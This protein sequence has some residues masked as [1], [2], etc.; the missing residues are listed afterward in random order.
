MKIDKVVIKNFRNY[1]GEHH[2][3]LS[4]DITIFYGDNGFGKSSFFD[5]IEWCISG[6]I[7]RFNDEGE[8]EKF[9]KDLINRYVLTSGENDIECCITMEFN[10]LKLIRKFN[11]KD[12]VFGNT[13]VKIT[14]SNNKTLR[15]LDGKPINSKEKADEFLSGIFQQNNGTNK[16]MFGKLMKQ[17]YILSQ[18]QVTEFVSS[19]DAVETFR[20]IANIMG[21]KPM[22][23]LSDNMKKIHSA[24]ESKNK[25]LSEDLEEKDKSILSKQ[26]TKRQV[27]I[28]KINTNLN[29]LSINIKDNVKEIK[30]HLVQIR[31]KEFTKKL[32]ADDQLKLCNKFNEE[33]FDLEQVKSKIGEL[34]AIEEMHNHTLESYKSLKSKAE[35]KLLELN[36]IKKDISSY[37]QLSNKIN[38]INQKLQ[39]S[40]P[41]PVDIELIKSVIK[42]KKQLNINY[43]FILNNFNNYKNNK[44]TV[45]NYSNEHKKLSEKLTKLENFK[46]KRNEI[47]SNIDKKIVETEDGILVNLL[48]NIKEINE[49]VESNEQNEICPVCSSK[50][51]EEGLLSSIDKNINLL[52]EKINVSSSYADKLLALKNNLRENI[53]LLDIKIKKINDE[54]DVLTWNYKRAKKE[55]ESTE[56]NKLFDSSL[57]EKDL[58]DVK[59]INSSNNEN[60]EKLNDVVALLLELEKLKQE[61]KPEIG[62]TTFMTEEKI[63]NRLDCLIR[64]DK[65]IELRIKKLKQ[66]I[67]KEEIIQNLES[68]V[69]EYVKKISDEHLNLPFVKIIEKIESNIKN[70]DN[71]LKL[72]SSLETDLEIIVHNNHV[73]EQIIQLKMERSKLN[74]KVT[75]LN[76]TTTSLSNYIENVF[77][78]FGN[79]AK[80]YLNQYY[81]P[82]Q[83]YFRYLNPLPTRSSIKFEG[84]GEKLFVKVI[85]DEHDDEGDITTP[86]NV[87]SSGQLNVLAISIFLGMNDS[88][89]IHELDFIAIDD[90][91][92]NMDDINQFSICDVLGSVK[93]QLIFSTHN[94]EFL[95]LFIK[96]NEYKKDTIQV[97]NFKSPFLIPEKVE[98]LTFT[99]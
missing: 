47:L 97:Y 77:G 48:N 93:K 51:E 62:N 58:K 4:K 22:L 19:E 50:F 78:D 71:T 54:M 72:V 20:S 86:K 27:D 35:N 43:Q 76:K 15:N 65:R 45:T 85:F 38:E 70:I 53:V 30:K 7:S 66:R 98:H 95:K 2:F 84:E 88:Q 81:S 44:V 10:G 37:N 31:D 12:K 46:K 18:D 91:I 74:E 42:D 99:N 33:F 75:N 57:M 21:F 24:L 16:N 87:L 11:C 14:D 94:F 55:I 28:Y 6:T 49:F 82:I 9:K 61:D 96:K 89:K 92:Q 36:R 64:A 68:E 60:I 63:S 67:S 13:S 80:D 5:A 83:K 39:E 23:K 41:Y 1:V 79:N 56:A 17:T 32:K 59:A 25:K 73:E 40:Q 29:T 8:S 52:K 26:E 3:D 69:Q 90:P 34:N